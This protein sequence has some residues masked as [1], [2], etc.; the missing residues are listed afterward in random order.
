MSD[1]LS[2]WLTDAEKTLSTGGSL[3]QSLYRVPVTVFLTGAL[4]AG[5]TTFLQGLGR[6]LGIGQRLTSPTYA[7]EQRYP[8]QH[9]G[10]LLHIDLYRLTHKDAEHLVHSSENH[11][12]IRCI[13]WAD[14]LPDGVPADE[15]IAVSL[16]ERA[17]GLG[18]ELTVSFRDIALPSPP[19]INAWREELFL[20]HL[21]ARHCDAVA[22]TAVRLGEEY[23]RRGHIVR[24]GALRAAAMTHDLLRFVD[25]HRG[26]GHIE[27]E[28]NPTHAR[29]WE[30]VKAQYADMRHEQAAAQFLT[31][32]GFPELAEIVR[33]HGLTLADATRVTTEQRLL[34]YADKR[35]K[36][37]EVVSLEERLRDFTVRYSHLGKLRESDAW[38][39]EARRTEHDLFPEGPPF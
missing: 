17:D 39:D 30:A 37:D 26:A 5:K 15:G 12:G 21:I 2:L 31:G 22:E 36:I 38:Y 10:E 8:T 11:H 23:A 24:L 35:V 9:F 1:S 3:A 29:T 25:F 34:Y 7:L 6:S 18:R 28:I 27:R 19:E 13:E 33:V 16:A 14:R 20:P 4:G 32:K